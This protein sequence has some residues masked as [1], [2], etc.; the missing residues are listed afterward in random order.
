MT[1]AIDGDRIISLTEP[2]VSNVIQN[3][4]IRPADAAD[5]LIVIVLPEDFAAGCEIELDS[6]RRIV[7]TVFY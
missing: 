1:I 4:A 5:D 2:D 3:M 7:T 6:T